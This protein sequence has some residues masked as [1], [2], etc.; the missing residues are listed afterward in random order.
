MCVSFKPGAFKTFDYSSSGTLA[1]Y[2]LSR[3]KCL[4]SLKLL[5]QRTSQ[6]KRVLFFAPLVTSHCVLHMIVNSSTHTHSHSLALW[7]WVVIWGLLSFSNKFRV[8]NSFTFQLLW[9]CRSSLSS[10]LALSLPSADGITSERGN[11][12]IFRP[13]LQGCRWLEVCHTWQ[14]P[15]KCRVYCKV[16]PTRCD[17]FKWIRL[18]L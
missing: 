10:S 13:D 1:M 18:T 5:V 7:V 16:S 2:H 9:T 6:T 11:R 12:K 8:R 14:A 15:G 4:K 3:I 17:I